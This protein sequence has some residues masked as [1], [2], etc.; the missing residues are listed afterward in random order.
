MTS[1]IRHMTI[2]STDAYELAGIW[3]QDLVE[4][5]R[6][7]RACGSPGQRAG[8]APTRAASGL[9]GSSAGVRPAPAARD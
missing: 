4:N 7:Q 9:S 1:A 3:S 5:T 6:G 8:S 2:D